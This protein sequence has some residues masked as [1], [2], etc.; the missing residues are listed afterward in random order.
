MGCKGRALRLKSTDNNV[1]TAAGIIPAGDD[2]FTFSVWLLVDT[3]VT[4]AT[5]IL[6]FTT[7]NGLTTSIA[8]GLRNYVF[9]LAN[10]DRTTDAT[11]RNWGHLAIVSV[12]DDNLHL[13]C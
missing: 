2:P 5:D 9:E 12:D 13:I 10:L 7:G 4:A 1:T 8:G 11:D 6:N 3:S